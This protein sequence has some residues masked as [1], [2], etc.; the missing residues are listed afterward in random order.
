MVDNQ[1]CLALHARLVAG[2]PT[3]QA[4]LAEHVW[5]PLLHAVRKNNLALRDRDLVDMACADALMSYVQRPAQYNPAKMKLFSYIV[6]AASGDL[7]NALAKGR[8]RR[9]KE[10]AI[11]GSEA[12]DNPPARGKNPTEGS[13]DEESDAYVRNE[14]VGPTGTGRRPNGQ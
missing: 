13:D 8:R 9:R 7:K 10:V 11:G 14:A 3:A 6:M 4:E 5:E 1:K 12:L 2:D